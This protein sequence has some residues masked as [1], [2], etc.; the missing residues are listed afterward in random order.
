MS[1]NMLSCIVTEAISDWN[2]IHNLNEV[3]ACNRIFS[4]LSDREPESP[5]KLRHG[6]GFRITPSKTVRGSYILDV[7]CDDACT[8]KCIFLKCCVILSTEQF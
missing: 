7:V 2:R 3:A 5:E 8:A 1:N 4:E 6:N